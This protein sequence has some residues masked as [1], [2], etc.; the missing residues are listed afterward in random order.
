M[1]A[2]DRVQNY[3]VAFHEATLARWLAALGAVAQSLAADASLIER[4]QAAD[5][6]FGERQ[7]LL[8]RILPAD[9]DLPVRN[10]LYTLAQHGD[11]ALLPAVTDALRRRMQPVEAAPLEVEVLSAIVLSDAQRQA[12]VARL[13]ASHGPGLAIRYK[14]D[15][16]ILGGMIVRVGDK[17]VDG[18]LASRLAAMK[19]ALGVTGDQGLGTRDSG[20][21]HSHESLIPNPD[22]PEPMR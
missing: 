9:L 20:D 7:M 22:K 1:S 13:E 4:I 14:V 18:S 2:E 8:D 11:L 12:L 6:D 21:A 3:A 17:L 15:P 5:V 10:L 16:T 19:Q